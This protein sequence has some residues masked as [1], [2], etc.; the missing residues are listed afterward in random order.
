MTKNEINIYYKIFNMRC[1]ENNF[2]GI[3]LI[4]NSINGTYENYIN[5]SHH[6]NYKSKNQNYMRYDNEKKHALLDYKEYTKEY[7]KENLSSNRI[8][9]IHTLVFDFDN[10]TR[11]FEPNRLSSSTV[12][13][14]NTEIDKIMF[15]KN[16]VKKYKKNKAECVDNILLINSWNEWGEKMAV[17]PSEECGYYY[18]NLIK[19]NLTDSS[20]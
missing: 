12:C 4:L 13:I 19:D 11:L 14:N 1:I 6:F 5:N 3:H 20:I 2:D 8:N 9:S 15:I 10:R 7:T 18:L 16:I 17:E